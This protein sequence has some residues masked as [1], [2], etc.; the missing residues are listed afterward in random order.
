MK[1]F[2][3]DLNRR[4]DKLEE[5]KRFMVFFLVVGTTLAGSLYFLYQKNSNPLFIFLW[6]L[7]FGIGRLYYITSAR[8]EKP[9]QDK[10]TEK[11]SEAQWDDE[12]DRINSLFRDSQS[13]IESQIIDLDELRKAALR[14]MEEIGKIVAENMDEREKVVGDRIMI[15]DGSGNKD[16]KTG[17]KRYGVDPLFQNN[18]AIVIATGCDVYADNDPYRDM[19]I[20]SGVDHLM[21]YHLDL[22]VAYQTGEEIYV[23]SKFVKIVD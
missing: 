7:I 20:R 9:N 1:K 14:N 18:K 2:I 5:P 22:L 4:F 16:K 12:K 23:A 6:L 13:F 8:R 15:W 10:A 21:G 11:N 19:H 3:I 17:E